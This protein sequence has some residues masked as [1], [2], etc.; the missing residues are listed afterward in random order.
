ME[1]DDSHK[2]EISGGKIRRAVTKSDPLPQ[3]LANPAS[4]PPNP[5]LPSSSNHKT[6]IRHCKPRISPRRRFRTGTGGDEILRG[7]ETLL[8][9]Q[10]GDEF[11]DIAAEVRNRRAGSSGQ[12][13]EDLI[14]AIGSLV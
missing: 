1:S 12:E 2:G 8:R 4:L 3:S 13:G 14:E 6:I 11:A 9:S 10:V 5:P 7:R